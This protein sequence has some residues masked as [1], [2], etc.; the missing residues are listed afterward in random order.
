MPDKII[1]ATGETAE[2]RFVL[3]DATD[4]ANIVANYHGAKAFARI[5]L[6]E[7][8]ASSLLLASGLKSNGTVQVKFQFSG[9]FAFVTAD[10]TPM[11]L[12]RGMLPAEEVRSIGD[13]EPLLSP[14]TM[15]VKKLNDKGIPISEGIVEMP[16]ENI[17][18]TTAYY[19]L[20][21]EQTKSA[22]GIKAKANPD[23]TLLEFCGGFLVEAFP[24][25]D[26]NTL[27]IMEQVVRN[28][29][30]IENYHRPGRPLD[31]DTLLADLAGPFKYSIH[32]EIPV[33]PFC[34]CSEAGVLK[35][36]TG[37]PREELE[38]IVLK[39]ETTELHCEYCRK[40]YVATPEQVRTLLEKMD[41]PGDGEAP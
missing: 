33:Q 32:R 5:L 30:P 1:R 35:A 16:S 19:L 3:V 25:A 13:F 39:N 7:T 34:P 10:A 11:G 23:G 37:L 18:P 20:Q 21:S 24:K 29:P 14:Q 27:A 26:E 9:D 36:M 31:L 22:V 40:R 8:I 38:E 4:T 2:I 15:S 12:V 17:G 6:G 41:R 28:L